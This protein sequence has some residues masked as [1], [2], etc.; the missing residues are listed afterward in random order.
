MQWLNDQLADYV[1]SL[2]LQLGVAPDTEI[3]LFVDGLSGQTTK[4]F[5]KAARLMNVL[6]HIGPAGTTDLTQAVDRGI[7]NMYKQRMKAR[8][9]DWL[10]DAEVLAL[11]RRN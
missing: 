9:D 4:E 2:R 3:L 1:V 5:I 10:V 7:G 6:V 11:R 8:L